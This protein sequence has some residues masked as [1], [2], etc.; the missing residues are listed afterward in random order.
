MWRSAM[1]VRGIG[2]PPLV[3]CALILVS[4]SSACADVFSNL[5]ALGNRSLVGAPAVVAADLNEGPK[6]IVAANFDGND[7]ARAD[8]ATSNLDGTI[9]RLHYEPSGEASVVS[10]TEHIETGAR[11]LRGIAAGDWNGDGIDDLVA[12]APFEGRLHFLISGAETE[13][14]S[15]EAWIG[16]RAVVTGDFNGDGVLEIAAAGPNGGLRIYAGDAQSGFSESVSLPEFSVESSVQSADF[17]GPHYALATFRRSGSASDSIAIAH[18]QESSVW[19]LDPV[20]DESRI[21]FSN[22]VRI[23]I[24]VIPHALT[25]APLGKDA[26]QPSLVVASK[27]SNSV[28]IF[29]PPP[30]GGDFALAEEQVVSIPNGPRAVGAIDMDGDGG[31]ELAVVLRDANKVALF[32]ADDNEWLT[33]DFEVTVGRSPRELAIADVNGDG[34]PDLATIN[35]VSEDVTLLLNA[36]DSGAFVE[37]PGN[38]QLNGQVVDVRLGDINGDSVADT[39]LL[40]RDGGLYVINGS[41]DGQIGSVQKVESPASATIQSSQLTV[42]D[43]N[44]D[45][46]ADVAIAEFSRSAGPGSIRILTGTTA[47]LQELASV[48]LPVDEQARL[49][50][51]KAAD[52]DGDQY[53][54]LVVGYSRARA[55]ILRGSGD[56]TFEFVESLP[57][58]SGA[59]ELAVGD[60]DGDA[61]ADVAGADYF[62][63]IVWLENQAE[64]RE[65]RW[66]TM[67][68]ERADPTFYGAGALSLRSSGQTEEVEGDGRSVLMGTS[69]GLFLFEDSFATARALQPES[70]AVVGAFAVG[71]FNGDNLPDI[72]WVCLPQQ[73]LV[74]LN[75]N[76]DRTYQEILRVPIPDTQKLVVGDVDGDDLDDL[77]G[78][79]DDLWFAF[80]GSMPGERPEPQL[81]DERFQADSV[82]INELLAKNDSI[83]LP[84]ETGGRPDYVEIFNGSLN[85]A[86]LT[87]W[88]FRLT[89]LTL[90]GAF[91]ETWDYAFP[92]DLVLESAQHQ[93]IVFRSGS[94]D[95]VESSLHTGFTLP[96][97]GGVLELLDATGEVVNAV[98]YANQIAD[99]SLARVRD[100]HRQFQLNASPDPGLPNFGIGGA[101]L[102]KLPEI[103]LRRIDY[104]AFTESTP[105]HVTASSS[106]AVEIA[107]LSLVYQVSGQQMSNPNRLRL[108]DDGEHGDG[109]PQDGV[110]GGSMINSFVPGS[111]VLFYLE[112][113]D[114][115]G[116]VSTLPKDPEEEQ[117]HVAVDAADLSVE[118][119]EA[120]AV[121]ETGIVDEG[122]AVEDWVELRNAGEQPVS[123]DGIEL[124]QGLFEE[125][126]TF[127]FQAGIVLQPGEYI[128]VFL[129]RD[130]GE[131]M[132]HAPFRLNAS[133]EDLVLRQRLESGAVQ[134]VDV[135]QIPPLQEDQS[136]ARIGS[137]GVFQIGRPSPWRQNLR[138]DIALIRDRMDDTQLSLV[139]R[140]QPG[141]IC[142]LERWEPSIS[143]EWQMVERFDGRGIEQSRTVSAAGESYYRV[144][145]E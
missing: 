11:T 129:D 71:D 112:A 37:L 34:L 131:G 88:K 28:H 93:L 125:A 85:A 19:V 30:T 7:E 21:Q 6:G 10:Q 142:V 132:F 72:A 42:G 59:R 78:L 115:S 138:A 40:L 135:L 65:M 107:A 145:H 137:A 117:F 35:R 55:A 31:N 50:S 17:P 33:F 70:K 87:G 39:L 5:R 3:F 51:I 124:T 69:T 58:V 119:S 126:G 127:A 60:F 2:V 80:S 29:S 67:T 61:D 62:G 109:A 20:V 66:G 16:V 77:V 41:H 136:F 8:L 101:V 121:N 79:G 141:K 73:C 27:R 74:I 116:A 134:L 143:E 114:Y 47:G 54:D 49:L 106:D 113:V 100:G 52:F 84:V 83:K 12:A 14:F 48:S 18:A 89:K 97:R 92:D 98:T 56:G 104:A 118:I 75:G 36:P 22:P 24:G 111:E 96:R 32:N 108:V 25:V 110:F 63:E 123:L 13:L 23:E 91:E 139:F 44:D 103:E 105:W 43:F 1:L 133:G 57:F 90:E 4:G 81:P 99:V 140:S 94:G 26:L 128:V 120:V 38:V 130:P 9:T 95:E 45:D 82:V 86:N 68:T 64:G 15:I 53:E 122:G 102:E 76:S 46:L 144:R